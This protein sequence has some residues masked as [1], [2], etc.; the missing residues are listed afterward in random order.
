[1]RERERKNDIEHC[2]WRLESKPETEPQSQ[3]NGKIK[4]TTKRLHSFSF[5][6]TPNEF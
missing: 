3:M 1:M 6:R 5:Q 2:S 4:W